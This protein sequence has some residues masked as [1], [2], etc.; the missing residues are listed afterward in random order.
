[1]T[2][3]LDAI[4]LWAIFLAFGI[5]LY[6][7]LE[8][9]YRLGQWRRARVSDEKD[10]PVGAM[11]ASILGLVALVLGFTFSLAASRFDA[12]RMAVLEESNAI[13]TAYLRARLLPEPQRTE[14]PRLLREYVAVRIQ[15]IEEGKTEQALARSEA[16]HELL[17]AQAAAAAEKDSG[18]IMTGV[19][20]QS[21]NDVIDL[22]A[23][24]VLVG[25]RS[26]IP[27][28][29][30]IGL[31][32]LAMLGMASVG[33]Q[34]ALCATRRSPAMLGMVL[35]FA[36]VL[37]LIA[38]L[39]RGQEGMMRISQHSMLDLQETITSPTDE[40]PEQGP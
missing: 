18:S 11:V 40:H 15:G 14:I 20:I 35:A 27:L 32:G 17:W 33:Y 22:H 7:A 5:F 4:P 10:Q 8:G 28:V 34:A 29:I 23:K 6:L 21:L 2:A 31:F 9:G 12:R 39:D 25:L 30:W 13:G 38:D 36:V 16:L 37:L 26:R 19:F 3:P 1:M 24:R